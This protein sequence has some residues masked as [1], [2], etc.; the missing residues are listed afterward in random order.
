VIFAG[1][2]GAYGLMVELRHGD[3]TTRYAHCSVILVRARQRVFRGALVARVGSTGRATAPHCH[4]EI[5]VG[6][7][8][9]DPV[10]Y[11]RRVRGESDVERHAR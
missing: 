7:R 6:G 9:V 2:A 10:E 1:D 8:A 11:L 5:R 3:T 4:Y